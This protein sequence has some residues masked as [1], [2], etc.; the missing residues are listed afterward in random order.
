MRHII[1]NNRFK[2]MTTFLTIAA[3][4]LELEARCKN[5]CKRQYNIS[6]IVSIVSVVY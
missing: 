6:V 4:E 3:V 5:P 1:L 2:L